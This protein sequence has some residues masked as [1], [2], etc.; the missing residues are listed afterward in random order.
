MLYFLIFI[1]EI[2][3]AATT[4][5]LVYTI[6]D[7]VHYYAKLEYNVV[8]QK[9]DSIVCK[10]IACLDGDMNEFECSWTVDE[11]TTLENVTVI[12]PG[13]LNYTGLAFTTTI[14]VNSTVDE[15]CLINQYNK[16]VGVI[17]GDNDKKY[18]NIGENTCERIDATISS[19]GATF[20]TMEIIYISVFSTFIF[21]FLVGFLWLGCTGG[22]GGLMAISCIITVLFVGAIGA[23]GYF[24]YQ[25]EISLVE[26]GAIIGAICAFVLMFALVMVVS[27]RRKNKSKSKANSNEHAMK[28]LSYQDDDSVSSIS[29]NEPAFLNPYAAMPRAAKKSTVTIDE[30][31]EDS[32]D[33]MAMSKVDKKTKQSMKKV[34]SEYKRALRSQY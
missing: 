16:N 14:K 25:E 12:P 32:I 33:R 7:D 29:R 15:N 18:C 19:T 31:F 28:N 20:N 23:I 9:L 13:N 6:R 2:C 27:T 22:S 4:K 8:Y 34:N 11:F 26:G 1:C 5:R 24:M 3:F 10:D 30:A 21:M 17:N